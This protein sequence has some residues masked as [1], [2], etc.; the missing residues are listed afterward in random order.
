MHPSNTR[1]VTPI[2]QVATNLHATDA[3]ELDAT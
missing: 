1:G 3:V 2:A